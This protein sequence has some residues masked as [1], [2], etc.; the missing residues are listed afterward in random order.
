MSSAK[1]N[2][3]VSWVTGVAC[4]V[5]NHIGPGAGQHHTA[6]WA[7][8]SPWAS[9]AELQSMVLGENDAKKFVLPRDV[10]GD[11]VASDTSCHYMDLQRL[12]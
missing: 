4:Q 6:S 7:I 10:A 11:E 3:P 1:N 5:V 12:A 8:M 9:I 2:F